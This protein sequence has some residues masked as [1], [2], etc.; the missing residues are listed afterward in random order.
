MIRIEVVIPARNEEKFLEPALKSLVEQTLRPSKVIVVNDGSTDRTGEIASK[1]ADIVIDLPDRGVRATGTPALAEVINRGLSE[2]SPDADYV[3]ILGADVILPPSFLE[4]I[5]SCMRRDGV[6]VASGVIEGTWTREFAVRG[7]RVVD[8]RWW[9]KYGLKYPVKFGWESWLIFRA[10]KDGLKVKA[11][12][13]IKFVSQ[14]EVAQ[15]AKRYYYWGKGMK[16]L[17]YWPPYALARIIRT[18]FRNPLKALAMLK[19]YLE[20][21]DQID[22]IRDFVPEFQKAY[23]K[24]L[25]KSKLRILSIVI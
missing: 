5:V 7:T 2:V 6:V 22:D 13:N 15:S 17:N 18:F 25:L 16:A 20:P 1:Y 14:R 19:G 11:Y 12:N 8:V 4:E 10:L 3:M 21:T 23:V 9:R 24:N